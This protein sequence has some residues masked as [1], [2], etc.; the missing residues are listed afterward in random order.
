MQLTLLYVHNKAWCRC[1]TA[2]KTIVGRRIKYGA[3]T[4]R[5]KEKYIYKRWVSSIDMMFSMY[6]TV[7][8]THIQNSAT[9]WY[10]LF[11]TNKCDRVYWYVHHTHAGSNHQNL[12]YYY[13][14]LRTNDDLGWF[15]CRSDPSFVYF[16]CVVVLGCRL[17][18]YYD[19]MII[20]RRFSAKMYR[21]TVDVY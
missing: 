20:W 11:L 17:F 1:V 19:A 7:S 12:P 15:L 21:S 18:L 14:P 13:R 2:D 4:T 8:K 5:R 10:W 16:T 3:W 9:Q 6:C